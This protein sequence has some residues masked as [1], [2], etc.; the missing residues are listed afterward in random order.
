MNN[1]ILKFAAAALMTTSVLTSCIEEYEPQQSYASQEEMADATFDGLAKSITAQMSGSFIYGGSDDASP[2]DCGYPALMIEHDIMGQDIT[3]YD[4]DGSEWFASWYSSSVALG[5]QYAVCQ[6]P[7]TYYYKWINSANLVIKTAGE[8]P[9]ESQ[10][11]GLGIAY[12]MRA[13]FYFDLAR[14]YA[15]KTYAADKTALTVPKVTE[16][17]TYDDDNNP[18]MTNEEAY[19]FILSDLDNAEKYIANYSRQD[20]TTPDLS[21]VYGLKARVYLTMEDWTNAEKY[22][23]LAQE[24]YAVMSESEYTSRT[25]GFNT[26]NSAWMFGLQYLATDDNITCNDGDSSWGSK[27]ITEQG[28]GCGYAA[29][30]GYPL[31]IDAHLYNSM[32]ATDCRKKCF[33]RPGI[34]DMEVLDKD[35]NYDA[36][37]TYQAQVEALSDYSDYPEYLY[38]GKQSYDYITVKFRNAGGASGVNNQYEGFCVAVP[39]MRVEEMY[40]IEA[41][42]V[43]MQP[44]REQEG[45]ELLTAFAKKRDANY[46]Y[47]THNEAYGNSTT[48]AFQNEVWWQRRAEFW[49][50]G[51]ATFDIK[52]LQKGIIRSYEGSN[53]VDLYRWNTTSVPEWMNMCLPR[54]E[55]SY[56]KGITENNPTPS[57]KTSND[58]E[59]VW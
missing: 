37:A 13:F 1:N 25:A 28:S 20:I 21:V 9:T 36:N 22:A 39:L 45:I 7:W 8:N 23:K 16:S 41:E 10:Y 24:G 17:N 34:N 42:A 49:C 6:L 12:C 40:L 2:Y 46:V 50:E 26:A 47:G 57:P 5:P 56:N 32:P 59:Y 33:V 53:H 55:T 52:R 51:L 3:P 44:G 19:K 14:L 43:G 29:N 15:P 48:S 58:D 31:Y 38:E 54:S 4:V 27:V 35:G 11:D 18:R 30:Y